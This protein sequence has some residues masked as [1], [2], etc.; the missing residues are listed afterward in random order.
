M[1]VS[2]LVLVVGSLFGNVIIYFAYFPIDMMQ[3]DADIVLNIP[4][5]AQWVNQM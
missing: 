4:L 2:Y 5:S 3:N 1:I